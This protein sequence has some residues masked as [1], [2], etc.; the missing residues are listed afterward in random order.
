M[1][2]WTVA[3][4]PL[5]IGLNLLVGL[6]LLAAGRRLFWLAVA[7]AGFLFGLGLAG[8]WLEA[9][10]G[11]LAFLLA[12]GVGLLGA[13]VALFLQRIAIGVAGFLIG[14]YLIPPLQSFGFAQNQPSNLPLL[15]PSTPPPLQPTPHGDLDY[16]ELAELS[17]TPAEIIDF[18]A[19]S[20]PYGA[21]PAVLVAVREAVTVTALRRYP[22]RDCLALRQAIAEAE[23]LSP[24]WILATNGANELIQLL[25]LAFV[26]PGR[27]QLVV[28]PTFG[29]YARAITLL[30]GRV[31]EYRAS[32][33]N[34]C[35]DPAAIAAAIYNTRPDTVWLCN[36]N[37]PTGQQLRREDLA[38]IQ[39]AAADNRSL[40]VIDESYRAFISSPDPRPPTPDLQPP[41]NPTVLLRSLT[42]EHGLAGL[43]L[44]YAAAAP[45]LIRLLRAVQ[46]AWSV[47]SLAQ[48]AGVTALQP[49]VRARQQENLAQLQQHALLLWQ[50][51]ST[52]GYPVLPT[53]TPY[54]LVQVGQATQFRRD[55]LALGL[56]VR[57]C[58]SFGLPEHVRIAGQLPEQNERLVAAMQKKRAADGAQTCR[59]ASWY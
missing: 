30:G 58:T 59:Q 7:A 14:S 39:S 38:L 9:Q 48:V 18:S 2:D 6:I 32:T 45:E 13:L 51:L 57:D 33:P 53:S 55:L 23:G 42:K 56:L 21:D 12:L 17:L 41:T 16:A 25:A 43:R 24:D 19:N 44:G 3:G 27:P 10:S 50:K 52:I 5:I 40:L 46:P 26:K 31:A 4:N 36:P 20:N 49:N 54:A 22:D 8:A 1:F 37:N 29:E 34:Y 47:N 11:G 28:A 15:H 35:F